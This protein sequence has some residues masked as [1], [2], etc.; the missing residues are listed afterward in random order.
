MKKVILVLFILLSAVFAVFPQ[1]FQRYS[2][3][4]GLAPNTMG[5]IGESVQFDFNLL[6][7]LTI[8]FY[9][10]HDKLYQHDIEFE[11]L[12]GP[13]R[14]DILKE[15]YNG[16]LKAGGDIRFASVRI[17]PYIALDA[18]KTDS[19]SLARIIEVVE[20]GPIPERY[21]CIYPTGRKR[22]DSGAKRRDRVISQQREPAP[23]D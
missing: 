4:I 15:V 12:G 6:R 10:N 2:G 18:S 7:F 3:N 8:G 17:Q 16:S 11:K 9:G 14:G 13:L 23:Q 5:T 20:T 1:D 21:L 22:G 19:D